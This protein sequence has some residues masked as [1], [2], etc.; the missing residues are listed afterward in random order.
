ML[1][2]IADN[3]KL[4]Y[5]KIGLVTHKSWDVSWDLKR[6]YFFN[7]LKLLI[8]LNLNSRYHN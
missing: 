6:N 2:S 1:C 8:E 7:Y 4:A 3:V 5:R